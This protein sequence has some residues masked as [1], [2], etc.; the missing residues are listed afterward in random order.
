MV[1]SLAGVGVLLEGWLEVLFIMASV[2][3]AT[4]SLHCGFNGSGD[5]GY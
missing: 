4:G 2:A 3:L 5:G 1:L